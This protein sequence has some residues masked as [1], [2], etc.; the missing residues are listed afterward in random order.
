[1]YP[2]YI[3]YTNPYENEINQYR[4]PSFSNLIGNFYTTNSP[5]TLMNGY[6]IPVSTRVFI[7]RVTFNQSSGE[8]MV[9]IVFPMQVGG[10]CIVGSVQ[11]SSS[12][13]SGGATSGGVATFGR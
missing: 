2:D 9:T 5:I 13:L 7:H 6:T 3:P 10:N 12:I 1:M 11:L 4:V 8:E